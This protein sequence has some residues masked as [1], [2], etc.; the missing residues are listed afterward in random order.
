[1]HSF[2]WQS[3]QQYRSEKISSTSRTVSWTNTNCKICTS[4]SLKLIFSPKSSG[5]MRKWLR[6]LLHNRTFCCLHKLLQILRLTCVLQFHSNLN[7]SFLEQPANKSYCSASFSETHTRSN[8]PASSCANW[9]KCKQIRSNN[10][11]NKCSLQ[12]LNTS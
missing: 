1:M 2:F 5:S 11:K 9:S 3:T 8:S 4:Y 12:H 7:S 10:L 6:L